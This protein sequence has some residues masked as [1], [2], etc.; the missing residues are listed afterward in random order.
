MALYSSNIKKCGK[1]LHLSN[2][3]QFRIIMKTLAYSLDMSNV[4]FFARFWSSCDKFIK[5]INM[6]LK[7][8]ISLLY[9]KLMF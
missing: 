5:V 4:D 2:F 1:M 8:N 7:C 9:Y 6:Y 3:G